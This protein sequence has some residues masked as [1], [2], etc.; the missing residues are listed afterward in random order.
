MISV[1]LNTSVTNL[2]IAMNSKRYKNEIATTWVY[3]LPSHKD[4]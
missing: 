1:T 3:N 2:K 4:M